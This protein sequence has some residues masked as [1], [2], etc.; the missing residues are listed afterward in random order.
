MSSESYRTVLSSCRCFGPLK[1][2][3]ENLQTCIQPHSP[4][5]VKRDYQNHINVTRGRNHL[6]RRHAPRPPIHSNLSNHHPGKLSEGEYQ[7]KWARRGRIDIESPKLD[8]LPDTAPAVL[9]RREKC[10]CT[11]AAVQDYGFNWRANCENSTLDNG[12][13]A[14][15]LEWN[16]Y[17]VC[18]GNPERLII[19]WFARKLESTRKNEWQNQY[20]ICLL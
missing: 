5:S 2:S 20:A 18:F 6:L 15:V 17:G 7:W 19:A 9:G 8:R 11:Q 14:V 10:A 3:R 12:F 16:G 1:C 13:R 4:S